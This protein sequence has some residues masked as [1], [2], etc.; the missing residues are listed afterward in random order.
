M[1]LRSNLEFLV[2]SFALLASAP[3]A[4]ESQTGG[5]SPLPV[6]SGEHAVGRTQFDWIDSSRAD[7]EN[8]K[9]HRE[10]VAWVWYPAEAPGGRE[11]VEWMPGA[12][13]L[14]FSLRLIFVGSFHT[15][16]RWPDH[17]LQGT[18]CDKY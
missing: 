4:L 12:A 11:S 10:V 5:A 15:E 17:P 7:S 13:A 1:R 18:P 3:A 2:A 16:S 9:R 14:S 8:P 6:P